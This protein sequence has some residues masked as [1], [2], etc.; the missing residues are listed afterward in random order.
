MDFAKGICKWKNCK[1][2]EITEKEMEECSFNNDC[3]YCQ[4]NTQSDGYDNNN[5]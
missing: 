1:V 2:N 5:D 3:E 4:M